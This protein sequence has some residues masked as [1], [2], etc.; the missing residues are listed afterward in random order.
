MLVRVTALGAA[1]APGYAV[2]DAVIVG[3]GASGWVD[4]SDVAMAFGQ[5][6]GEPSG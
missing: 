6:A 3:P 2:Q 4:V 5:R 1:S